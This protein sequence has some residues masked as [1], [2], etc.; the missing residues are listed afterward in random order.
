[1]SILLN[2]KKYDV[3]HA[4][5]KTQ[6]VFEKTIAFFEKKGLKSIKID[7]QEGRWYDDFLGFLKDDGAFATLLTPAGYGDDPDTRFDLSRIC[8]YNELLAFYALNYQYCYQVTILGMGP[9]WSGDNEK[10]KH[11][12]AKALKEGGI[13]AFGLS[14]KE[15]GADLYSNEMKLYPQGDGAYKADGAKYY[16]GNG[17]AA[18]IVSTQGRMADTNE[19]VYFAVSPKHHNYK[20]VK[21][22]STS[23]IRMCYVAEY[24]LCDYPITEDDIMSK[25]QRA[26]DSSLGTVNLGKFELGF[27]SIGISTHCLYE[28]I[29]HASNRYLYGHSVT[30]FAHIKNLFVESYARL[31][32]MKLYALRSLDYFRNASDE[33]RRYLLFNPIQKMKVTTEAV[34]VVD[35]LLD[36]VTAKGFEQDTYFEMA[37][38][39]IGMIPRLEGTTH[40]NIGLVTKFIDNYFGNFQEYAEIPKMDKPGDDKYVWKQYSG[41]LHQIGFPD[42]R[43]AYEGI[44]LPNVNIFKEQIELLHEYM[45]NATPSPEHRKN[46]DYMLALGEMLTLIVYAQLIMEN[47][48]IYKI[49]GDLV[50]EI[51][52]FLVRDFSKFALSQISNYVS[53]E[54]QEKILWEMIRKPKVDPVRQRK[55]WEAHIEPLN[56]AYVMND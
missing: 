1:M 51:F 36:I 12:A 4:D 56:G 50:D 42:Y 45:I 48:K 41:K 8:P 38:R 47:C 6:E 3:K 27:A 15:H 14:E 13:L 35:M 40:V 11:D 22:I 43:K 28:A 54:A 53:T 10:I 44:D 16:I 55:I 18:A 21:K 17:N 2:P 24:E 52:N 33:D 39:D 9:I 46:L 26:W 23:G 19:E 30:A 20:L 32:A 29:N 31:V 5:Q 25:G 49:D 7:D 37:I 34:K